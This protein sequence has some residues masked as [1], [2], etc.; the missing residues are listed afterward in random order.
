MAVPLRQSY[1]WTKALKIRVY[2]FCIFFQG[3]DCLAKFVTFF[4]CLVLVMLVDPNICPCNSPTVALGKA[5]SLAG[6]GCAPPLQSHG[7]AQFL[8]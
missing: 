6:V 7:S 4:F 2:F 8:K 3:C 5:P 1:K